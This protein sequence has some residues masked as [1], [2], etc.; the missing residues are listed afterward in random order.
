MVSNGLLRYAQ[1]V[2]GGVWFGKAVSVCSGNDFRGKAGEGQLRY[3]SY[4]L[5]GIGWP[6]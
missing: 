1:V 3:G 2:Q 6:V 5:D 4:G